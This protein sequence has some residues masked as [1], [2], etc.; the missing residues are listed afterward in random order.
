MTFWV[1]FLKT[2]RRGGLK[3]PSGEVNSPLQDL[4]FLFPRRLEGDRIA[5]YTWRRKWIRMSF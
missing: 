1:G 5:S 3:P 4:T 2:K